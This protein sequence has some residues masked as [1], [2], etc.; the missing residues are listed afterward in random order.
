M[1]MKT[2]NKKSK[3]ETVV[4]EVAKKEKKISVE[5]G[6]RKVKVLVA[7]TFES[8][9]SDEAMLEMLASEVADT[10]VNGKD[11]AVTLKNGKTLAD[12][13]YLDAK[14]EKVG[15]ILERKEK[16]EVEETETNE[17]EV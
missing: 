15:R 10:M 5:K 6:P 11:F 3:L 12:F 8:K 9:A 13:T 2:K 7:L 4:A 17:E 14:V 16:V 1:I